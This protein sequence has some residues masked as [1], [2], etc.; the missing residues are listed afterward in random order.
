[1]LH[2]ALAL[3]VITAAGRRWLWGRRWRRR[4]FP[5]PLRGNGR[6]RTWN[7]R[8]RCVQYS[9]VRTYI[10]SRG[11]WTC[12]AL[13]HS[14]SYIGVAIMYICTIFNVHVNYDTVLYSCLLLQYMWVQ[15]Q[16]QLLQYKS[17]WGSYTW[18]SQDAYLVHFASKKAP[19]VWYYC[20]VTLH[21]I[22]SHLTLLPCAGNHH[23]GVCWCGQRRCW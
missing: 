15:L 17:R 20:G 7:M 16:L 2:C 1:M 19:T 14:V 5:L 8:T 12:T 10:G 3:I 11:G 6:R 9:R 21:F 4:S 22:S 13:G 23:G 18:V